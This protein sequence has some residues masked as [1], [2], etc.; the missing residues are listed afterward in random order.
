MGTCRSLIRIAIADDHALVRAGYRRLLELE[1]GLQVVAEFV[2]GESAYQ[3]LAQ[4]PVEVLILD[5]SMPGQ[6]GLATLQRL[7]RRQPR[8][9]VLVFTMHDS[10]ALALQVLKAGAC[11]FL[12][13]SSPPEH[14]VAAVKQVGDGQ[15]VVSDA[16]A[17]AMPQQVP[18]PHVQLSAREFDIFLLLASGF[19]VEA[20]ASRRCLSIKT[21]A[22]YQTIVRRKLGLTSALAMHRYALAHGLLAASSAAA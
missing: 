18:A 8:L 16:L 5:L 2:D 1:P 9:R 11:G 22:N 12:S 7:H 14:L 17:A 3:G 20:V 4:Q 13:K 10:A 21:A 19:T 15:R 6:G